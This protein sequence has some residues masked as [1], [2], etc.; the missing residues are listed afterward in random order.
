MPYKNKFFRKIVI[1]VFLLLL[2]VIGIYVYSYQTNMNV[3]EEEIQNS[4]MGQLSFFLSQVE[5]NIAQLTLH[6]VTLS[7]DSGIRQIMQIDKIE[8][9]S[10]KIAVT[11]NIEERL[12]LFSS[13]SPWKNDLSVYTPLSKA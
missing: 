3:V 13:S 2:P 9:Y 7:K 5:N 11:K 12:I 8:T 4:S 6:S 1:L 10:E